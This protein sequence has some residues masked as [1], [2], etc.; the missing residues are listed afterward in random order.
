[1][2]AGHCLH[3]NGEEDPLTASLHLSML[4]GFIFSLASAYLPG[5]T[6]LARAA[7]AIQEHV[8]VSQESWRQGGKRNTH[9]LTEASVCV[10]RWACLKPCVGT[11]KGRRLPL[12][13]EIKPRHSIQQKTL[14]SVFD[15]NGIEALYRS[16]P[17]TERNHRGN[18]QSGPKLRSRSLSCHQ[19]TANLISCLFQQILQYKSPHLNN[20]HIGLIILFC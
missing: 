1:M 19:N 16:Q 9:R 3:S 11:R 15:K 18:V 12:P 17:P 13:W 7:V 6:K 10:E 2:T 8:S 5:P 20:P 4:A 14:I